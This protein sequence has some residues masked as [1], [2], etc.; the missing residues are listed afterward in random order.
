MGDDSNLE[1]EE[2]SKGPTQNLKHNIIASSQHKP[3]NQSLEGIKKEEKG[4]LVASSHYHCRTSFQ[5]LRYDS[6]LS[7]SLDRSASL[8]RRSQILLNGR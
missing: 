5:N 2:D 8:R 4:I 7:L 3:S 1:L 6:E